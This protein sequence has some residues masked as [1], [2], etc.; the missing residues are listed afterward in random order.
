[1]DGIVPSSNSYVEVITTPRANVRVFEDGNFG[2]IR[3]R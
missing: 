1:M 3:F 2:V